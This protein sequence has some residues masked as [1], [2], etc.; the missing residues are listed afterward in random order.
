MQK[1]TVICN[2]ED[3]TRTH[4]VMKCLEKASYELDLP[5]PIWLGV[6]VNDFKMHNKCRF[7]QDSFIEEVPFDFMEISVIEED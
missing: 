2:D 1:D 5:K 7:T 3:D 4:K 6:N